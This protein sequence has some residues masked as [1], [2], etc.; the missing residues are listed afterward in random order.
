[1]YIYDPKYP[2][3]PKRPDL[4]VFPANVQISSSHVKIV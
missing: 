1:M 2:L 4:A 3:K